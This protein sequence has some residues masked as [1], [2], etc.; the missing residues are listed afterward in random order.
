LLTTALFLSL[1][2]AIALSGRAL[3]LF[4]SVSPF[5]LTERWRLGPSEAGHC[6]PLVAGAGVGGT[7][8]VRGLRLGWAQCADAGTWL[9]RA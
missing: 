9:R 3:Y 6:Y 2:S 5:L 8:V 7:I 4:L 1:A